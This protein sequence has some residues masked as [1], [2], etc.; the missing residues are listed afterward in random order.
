MIRIGEGDECGEV[1]DGGKRKVRRMEVKGEQEIER[2]RRI[3]RGKLR[4]RVNE[5]REKGQYVEQEEEKG[6]TMNYI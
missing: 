6:T 5:R 4:R 2:D 3:R 1:R